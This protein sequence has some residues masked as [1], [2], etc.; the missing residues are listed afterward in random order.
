MTTSDDFNSTILASSWSFESGSNASYELNALGS[1]AVLSLLTPDGAFDFWGNNRNAARVLQTT[2]NTDFTLTTRFTSVPTERYQMQGFLVGGEGGEWIRIDTHSDGNKLKVFAAVISAN[3]QSTVMVSEAVPGGAAPYLS[4]QR[5]GDE[6][7]ASTSA[8]GATFVTAGTF[9]HAMT[10]TESGLFAGNTGSASGFTAHADYFEISS[11]PLTT[12]DGGAPNA[13]PDAVDDQLGTDADLPLD[14]SVAADL[15]GND[16]DSD[17]D[18]LTL[19]GL[20]QPVNGTVVDD[21]DGTLTYTPN[22]GFVGTDTFTY[23]VS[24]GDATDTATVTVEVAGATGN[25]LTSDDFSSAALDPVWSVAGAAG[26]TVSLGSEG[27]DDVVLLAT[28]DGNFDL[29]G[30]A[31]NAARLVQAT[32]DT[33]FTLNARFL[34]VPSEKFQMQGFIVEANDG[35]WLRVDTYFDGSKLRLFAAATEDG[36]SS[37]L[38]SV[39]IPEGLAP[40]LTLT[41]VG[42]SFTVAYSL[43]GVTY[44]EVGSFTHQM[45]VTEAGLFA[46]NTGDADGFVAKV[47]WF[48]VSG[49]PLT[50]EDGGSMGPA[51]EA[52][53]DEI[54]VAVHGTVVIDIA[55]DLLANDIGS[56]L[57]FAGFEQPL[58]GTL[59]DN[60]DGTLTYTPPSGNSGADQFTYTVSNGAQ[61]SSASVAVTV[62]EPALQ[63]DDFDATDLGPAW[64][65]EG[66]SETSYG[67][68]D[69]ASDAFLALTTPD[70]NFDLW[71]GTKSV[72]RAMQRTADEDFSLTARFLSAPTERFQMQGFL[73]DGDAGDWLRIDTYSDGTSLRIFA[74]AT[75]GD[76]STILLSGKIASGV[77]PYLSVART[78]DTWSVSHSVDGVTW[79]SAGSFTHAMTVTEA[80]LFAGNTGAAQ[81]FTAEVDWFAVDSDPLTTEDGAPFNRAPITNADLVEVDARLKSTDEGTVVAIGDLIGNDSDPDGDPLSLLSFTQPTNAVVVDNGDGTLT[82]T[83]VQ[84]FS[85]TDAFTYTVTDGTDTAVATVTLSVVA[86]EV[87]VATIDEDDFSG[88]VLDPAWQ[89]GGTPGTSAGLAS[90]GAQ[91]FVRLA[92]S[93]ASHDL[94]NT[95]GAARLTQE[96]VDGDLD[97]T[98]KFLTVPQS[99]GE[100]QGL[101]FEAG[102]G[103]WLSFGVLAT[104]GGAQVIAIATVAG[105]SSVRLS[106]VVDGG[107]ASHLRVVREGDEWSLFISA[108][109]VSHTKVGSF[110]QV[111]TVSDAG[112]FAASTDGAFVADVDYVVN[113][114][115]GPASED[116]AP[117]NTPPV[118]EADPLAVDAGGSLLIDVASDLLGNDRDG[119]GDALSLVMVGSPD[120]GTLVDNLD[121]TLTYTPNAG[122]VGADGFAYRVGDGTDTA[123]GQ[124]TVSVGGGAGPGA[125]IFSDDFSGSGLDGRWEFAGIDGGASLQSAG[126]EAYL[127]IVSPVGVAVDA[128][129]SL[130]TTRVLQVIAAGDFDATVK[131]LNEPSQAFQEHGLLLVED[132]ANWIRYDLAYTSSGLR[133]IVAE[134]RGNDRD[135]KLF[136]AVDSGDVS[137]LRVSRDGDDYTFE[138]SAD[139]ATWQ[140]VYSL[141]STLQPV[142]VGP[143]AGS[144]SFD[145]P[146]PGFTS[147]VDF[148]ETSAD[149]LATDDNAPP[150]ANPDAL[151]TLVDTPLVVDIAADLLANDSDADGEPLSL[152]AVTQPVGGDVVD[153]GDGTL[154]VAPDPG[155]VGVLSLTATVTDGTDTAAGEVFVGVREAANA[156]PQAVDDAAS[157]VEGEAVTVAV[158]SNDSDDGAGALSLLA[159]GA[160]SNG[161]LADLGGGALSYTPDAGFS[162]TDAFTYTVSDGTGGIASAVV[163]VSVADVAFAPNAADDSVPG[164]E[165]E[166]IV[167][168]IADLLANDTDADGDPLTL[169]SFTQPLRGAVSDNGDGT[170][171]VTPGAG[172][173]GLD[174][175]TYTV[176]DGTDTDV[177]H[178]DLHIA[179]RFGF[180]SDDFSGAVSDAPWT[181]EGPVGSALTLVEDGEGF[182]RLSVPSGTHDAWG[183]VD[184]PRYLQAVGDTD[185]S[186]E[187]KFLSA[188]TMRTQMQG[189]LIEEDS[190]DWIRFDVLHDGTGLHLFAALTVDGVS[191]K[192]FET[193]IVPGEADYFHVS[194]EGDRFDFAYSADGTV[195]KS[196][197]SVVAGLTVTA[198]GTFAAT[199]HNAPGHV[200]E[201]DYVKL[202]G[203]P[204]ADDVAVPNPPVVAD[205]LLVTAVDTA[206]VF[207]EADLLANDFDPNGEPLSVVGLGTAVGGTLLDLGGGT[208]RFTPGAGTSGVASFTYEVS[209]GT[210]GP[211]STGRVLVDIDNAAPTAA[212]DSASGDEETVIV[213]DVL[214][215][216]DD[217]DGDTLTVSAVGGA[218]H[219]TITI[220]PD[221]TIRYTPDADTFGTDSF[222]YSVTDGLETDTATVT[223]TVNGTDDPV[224]AVE[225]ALSTTPDAP[226]VIDVAADLFGNDVELDGDSLDLVTFTDPGSGSLV[227]NGDGTL[228]FTPAAGFEGTTSFSYTVSDGTGTSTATVDVAVRE[229][230]DVWYGSTQTFGAPGQSQEW[231]NILGNVATNGLVSLSYSL[232]GGSSRP[233][234]VGPDTRRLQEH[235]DFNVD[236]AYAE[237]DPSSANDEVTITATYADGSVVSEAVSVAFED[238]AYWPGDY[239]IDWDTVTGLQ[240]VVQVVDGTWAIEADGSGVRPVDL[241]YDRLLVLGDEAWD[242]YEMRLSVTM[243][244]LENVDP[245]GRDGGAFAIGMLWGGHTDSPKSGWQPKSGWEPG[246]AFFYTEDQFRLH[247]YHAFRE[248]LGSEG[249]VIQ[250]GLTYEMAVRVEQVGLYDR[251]YSLKIWEGGTP[252]PTEWTITGVETFSI[253]EAPATGSIY[254]NAHYYDV[255]F[256]DLTVTEIV[257]HDVIAGTE[258]ADILTAVNASDPAPG[259]GEVDVFVGEAGADLFIVG[260]ADGL[261]YDDGIAGD[262]GEDEF[263]FVWDFSAAEDTV[264]LAGVRADYALDASPDAILAG[265]VGVYHVAGGNRELV[266]V[267]NT[268]DALSLSRHR[269]STNG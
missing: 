48:E 179:P 109:G 19:T 176:S 67:L 260:D 62:G 115:S 259:R 208:Y 116:G 240:D 28:P 44:T 225:D 73:V 101:L 118:A 84:G 114:A 196:A 68:I 261:F 175:F 211:T 222:T 181:L 267:L 173:F 133:L 265:G 42:D 224:V 194:R 187:A 147:Q 98:T 155:F 74:A 140:T 213:V 269:N 58:Q 170:L 79:I 169:V 126:A 258:G 164:T 36:S 32:A 29:W 85:G 182:L 111:I 2:A 108:D 121:G 135:I 201:V 262:E 95:N 69:E 107:E 103:D 124:V 128:L 191:S 86:P 16:T 132:E 136:Q 127:Q 92:T 168:A 57:T 239:A 235:G 12:A 6:W 4:V 256:N 226:L 99:A 236:L 100:N 251:L 82:V 149:P 130:T 20:S 102:S 250:E 237:L 254:L 207:S 150:V 228:T 245:S 141:A 143:F 180:V 45:T 153:N 198:V 71:N 161:T 195:W 41:R 163:T 22:S 230:I 15:L 154:T 43:D 125:A 104:D 214:A 186:L 47:D 248:V 122:F 35:D 129:N 134:V 72:A 75:A 167:I 252:E 223:V 263:A 50:S 145:G 242:N 210:A 220:L 157:T 188:P 17:G 51:P 81:G 94:W 142:Q 59:V 137:H 151:A 89:D 119:E 144:T 70:G 205:D 63:S 257:G 5:V 14:I 21:G 90:E 246:A 123:V 56:A 268:D 46:G 160:A 61:Q 193:A 264:Q 8:D 13:S 204:L 131:F 11:D 39:V 30:S 266:A 166:P 227:A 243:H 120:N 18:P 77:A 244:D 105:V 148:F 212:D 162:G 106:E 197:G 87:I 88:S 221:G 9:T 38:F 206:L 178:V 217:P 1:D 200:A 7:T 199:A 234:S 241:G 64:T 152:V 174:G 65:F 177:G 117:L 33:D 218:A 31:K 192:L 139:G 91:S 146:A 247:S 171:T 172:F 165:A 158:T 80:G 189:L 27:D 24:D 249:A 110:A 49:D 76:Q 215:N 159:I 25:T 3:G 232:N 203:D 238:G 219:G 23:D 231:I 138:A 54:A 52:M 97:V 113:G 78:G 37:S 34:S 233:L 10:V 40:Y 255:A 60:G 26:A 209:D 216:D 112:L 183:T 83:P 96:V 184:G 93:N 53:A 229:V 185:F 55:A 156:A 202:S 253:D 190:G 66:P